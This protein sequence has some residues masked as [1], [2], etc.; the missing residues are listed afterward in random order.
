MDLQQLCDQLRSRGKKQDV[1]GEF[2]QTVF[3]LLKKLLDVNP[4]TRISAENAL[5]HEFFVGVDN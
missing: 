2:P 4:N 3:D 1:K 5:K